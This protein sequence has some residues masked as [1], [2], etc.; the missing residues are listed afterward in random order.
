MILYFWIFDWKKLVT[1]LG[2]TAWISSI[3]LGVI[4]YLLY[5]RNGNLNA[6]SFSIFKKILFSST[7]MTVILSL[8]AVAIELVTNSMP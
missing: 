3:V 5:Q 1:G 7:L 4:F 2:L 6:K 8:L